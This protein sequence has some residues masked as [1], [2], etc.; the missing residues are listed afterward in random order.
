MEA[1][2]RTPAYWGAVSHLEGQE[3]DSGGAVEAAGAVAHVSPV[4][5]PI[6]VVRW[7]CSPRATAAVA[8]PVRWVTGRPR[9]GHWVTHRVGDVAVPE[10]LSQQAVVE[11][12]VVVPQM[13]VAAVVAQLSQAAVPPAA[14]LYWACSP[15]VE[16]AVPGAVSIQDPGS[17][18][19]ER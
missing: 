12:A 16:V 6:Q 13:G 8:V 1:A 4:A 7:A 18:V 14:P 3:A 19:V 11:V 10:R 2:A 9:V 17:V 15:V 5:P